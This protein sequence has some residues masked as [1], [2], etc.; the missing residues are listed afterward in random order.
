MSDPA[1][2]CPCS[3]LPAISP[4]SW[5]GLMA[6][7]LSLFFLLSSSTVR[8]ALAAA[9]APTI[10]S[11]GSTTSPGP[12]M[13]PTFQWNAVSGA[14]GYGLDIRDL[15][16]NVLVYPNGSGTKTTPLTGTS[17][18][19]PSGYL[20]NSHQYRW[21]MTSFTG[22]TESAQSP[23]LYFQTPEPSG[24]TTSEFDWP[25]QAIDGRHVVTEAND[26]DGW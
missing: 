5:T 13:T 26:E 10:T 18:T 14:T 8:S 6:W 16:T 4:K 12:T 3:S 17:Y 20:V 9:R 11:P 1:F 24:G 15:T 2:P 21:G 23:L 22:S 7:L 25:L 19:L